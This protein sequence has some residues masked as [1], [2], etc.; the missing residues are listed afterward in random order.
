MDEIQQTIASVHGLRSDWDSSVMAWWYDCNKHCKLK[1]FCLCTKSSLLKSVAFGNPLGG[2]NIKLIKNNNKILMCIVFLV[3]VCHCTVYCL[4]RQV[5][6]VIFPVNL[7]L[8]LSTRLFVHLSPT[9]YPSECV[10]VCVFE[11]RIKCL[12]EGDFSIHIS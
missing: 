11:I 5:I 1:L 6:I 2:S 8:C 9:I 3:F 12:T 10:C 4:F 7:S